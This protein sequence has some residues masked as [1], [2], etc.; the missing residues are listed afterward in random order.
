MKK[1]TF[2]IALCLLFGCAKEN[3]PSSLETDSQTMTK[4]E[5]LESF[6]KILSKAVAANEPIREFIKLKA[7]EQFDCDYDVFYPF[8]KDEV[9]SSGVTFRNA[10]L[11]VCEDPEELSKIE[12]ACPKLNILVPDWSWIGAFNAYS[13]ETSNADVL[14]GYAQEGITHTLFKDGESYLK[15]SLGEI[16]E[17]PTIIVKENERMKVISSRSDSKELEYDFI[18]TCF[19]GRINPTTRGRAWHED[20]INLNYEVINN[21]VPIEDIDPSLINAYNEFGNNYSGP[22][23][24][25]D[26]VYYNMSNSNQDNGIRNPYIQERFYR[27]RLNPSA[28]DSIKGEEEDPQLN[29]PITKYGKS[30]QLKAEDLLN[31]IWSDGSFE[32]VFDF[33][34]GKEGVKP[35]YSSCHITRSARASEVFDL[36]KVHRKYKHQTAVAQGVYIYSFLAENLTS[37]WINFEEK[38][39]I[40]TWDISE[41]SNNIFIVAQELDNKGTI[42]DKKKT[43]YTYSKN[44]SITFGSEVGAT[45]DKIVLKRSLG[46]SYTTQ[47]QNTEENEIVIVKNIDSETLGKKDLSFAERIIEGPDNRLIDNI[48][49]RGYTV[50]PFSLGDVIITVLPQD[51]RR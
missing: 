18:D 42:T 32:F 15:L 24:Q 19:D 6:A 20:N 44:F 48:Y 39:F 9:L 8:V 34:I 35:T 21:F 26:Y 43:T 10:L 41:Q 45:T 47:E 7:I 29:D 1:I 25:R 11:E 4:E 17:A 13:W 23:C 51:I 38:T 46:L 3:L 12:S 27:F 30:N 49:H 5:A 28:Y 40:P 33:Y 22:G 36:T 16:P 14:V 37:K 31:K 50:R 2:I